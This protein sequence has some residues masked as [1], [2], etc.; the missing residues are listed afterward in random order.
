MKDFTASSGAPGPF[1]GLILFSLGLFE[2]NAKDAIPLVMDAALNDS[3]GSV[4]TS[5]AA[6]L[7][8]IDP[9]G[10]AKGGLK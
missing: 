8:Q 5:A 6:A 10:A 1:R 7:K 4:R 3:N 9:N 2:T